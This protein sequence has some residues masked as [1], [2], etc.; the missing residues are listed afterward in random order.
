MISRKAGAGQDSLESGLH[1]KEDEFEPTCFDL[2]TYPLQC[3]VHKLTLPYPF[4]AA[5]VLE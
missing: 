2:T 3:Q 4:Q 5:N 1:I